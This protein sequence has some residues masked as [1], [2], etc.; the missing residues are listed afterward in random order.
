MAGKALSNNKPTTALTEENSFYGFPVRKPYQQENDYF[1][2]NPHV[3]GM[4]TEDNFI[5]MNPYS[6]LSQQQ[7]QSVMMNEATRLYLRT[8]KIPL[9]FQ[10]TEQQKKQFSGYS[11]DPNDIRSTIIGR[12]VS[13]DTSALDITP[14]QQAMAEEIKNGLVNYGLRPDGTQ[15]GSGFLGALKMTDGSDRDM[16]EFSIGVNIDG[17]EVLIPSIVPTLSKEEIEH[18]LSGG[19]VTDSIVRKAVE[20][21]KQRMKNNQSPFKD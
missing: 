5:T 10:L 12:I 17:K 7:K 8:N 20:H 2:T 11:K 14:E 18:L 15:K 16:T 21:A 6:K 13:G 1:R 19:D 3:S 4:A 9:N